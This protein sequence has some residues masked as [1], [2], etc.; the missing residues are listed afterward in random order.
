MDMGV[1][2]SLRG[3]VLGARLVLV[4]TA[5]LVILTGVWLWG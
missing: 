3:G 5:V 4:V 1:G 2:E